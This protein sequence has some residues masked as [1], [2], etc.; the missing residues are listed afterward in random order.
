M[1]IPTLAMPI[2]SFSV[3]AVLTFKSFKMKNSQIKEKNT[4][5]QTNSPSLRE[6]SLPNTPVKPASITAVCKIRN[7]LFIQNICL[8]GQSVFYN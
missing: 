7:D 2:F 5:Y 8:P 6:I 4:L 3:I 1:R